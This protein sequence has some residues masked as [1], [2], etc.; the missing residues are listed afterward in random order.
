MLSAATACTTTA[1]GLTTATTATTAV[2]TTAMTIAVITN[3]GDGDTVVAAVTDGQDSDGEEGKKYEA[4]AIVEQMQVLTMRM[5][6]SNRLSPKRALIS[7]FIN[8]VS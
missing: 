4:N 1:T 3:D 7:A 5:R 6:G 8:P 2:T